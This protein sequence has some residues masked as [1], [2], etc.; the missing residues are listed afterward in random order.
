MLKQNFNLSGICNFE[1]F[2]QE[3]Y[4]DQKLK[5]LDVKNWKP[6]KFPMQINSGSSELSD[7]YEWVSLHDLLCFTKY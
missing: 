6:E 7:S 5:E 1:F 3:A 2:N 4:L